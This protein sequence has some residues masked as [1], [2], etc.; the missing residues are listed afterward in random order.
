MLIWA[1]ARAGYT[2]AYVDGGRQSTLLCHVNSRTFK[3]SLEI[4]ISEAS[5]NI[6]YKH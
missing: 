6:G 1:K 3:K 4:Q 2:C 5:K